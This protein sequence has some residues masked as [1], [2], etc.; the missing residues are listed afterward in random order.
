MLILLI[1]QN[2][3]LPVRAYCLMTLSCR[4]DIFLSNLLI[5]N[6]P[7]TNIIILFYLFWIFNYMILMIRCKVNKEDLNVELKGNSQFGSCRIWTQILDRHD[8]SF[9]VRYKMMHSCDD[10]EIHITSKGQHLGE[11]PYKFNDRI[12]AETCDCPVKDL[13]EMISLYQCPKN[14][15]QI[16]H[17]LDKFKVVEFKKV[18]KE[19]IK[20]FNHAG[21]YSFCHYAILSNKVNRNLNFH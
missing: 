21:S 19:S 18:L 8:G 2:V 13:D 6:L 14:I 7:T 12:Y 9:I 1:I 20:R 3:K 16:N 11:S 15:D 5:S 10:L 4:L 17:D